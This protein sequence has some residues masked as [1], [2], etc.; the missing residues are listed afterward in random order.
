MTDRL[1][2]LS[3]LLAELM[4]GAASVQMLHVIDGF[5]LYRLLVRYQ[6]RAA[7]RSTTASAGTP[8]AA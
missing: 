8:A 3:G 6:L 2:P 7:I 5:Y 1:R 4:R